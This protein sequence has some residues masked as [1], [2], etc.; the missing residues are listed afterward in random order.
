M[1]RVV[2][3]IALAVFV[4]A[5]AWYFP[6]LPC[7]IL[8]LIAIGLGLWEYAK[9]VFEDNA[10][11]AF[12]IVLGL[13]FAALMTWAPSKEHISMGLITA[14]FVAFLWGMAHRDPLNEAIHRVGLL[15]L[16]VCYLS[17]TLPMWSWLKGWGGQW[18]LMILIPAC[19]TDTFGFLVGKS[20]GKKKLASVISP[21]KTWEGFYG[22][23][24]GSV[25]GFWFATHVIAHLRFEW[26][27]I[28]L[29]GLLIGVVA[30]LGDLIES[31]IKRS[32]S[33]KDSSHL[34]PG[35][36]GVLDRLDALT[37]TAPLFYF[38]SDYL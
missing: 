26:Y 17:L 6:L 14:V 13:S 32:V 4:L 1:V 29:G 9:L 18:V 7:Q 23:L 35:H 3:T 22:G 21:N 20:L 10:T 24:V 28:I 16:G 31:T 8:V 27:K 30:S 38:L 36:G 2:T 5:G 37:F 11:R 33:V 19:L 15:I 34:I 12:Q 25:L